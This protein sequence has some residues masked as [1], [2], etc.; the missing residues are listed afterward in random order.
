MRSIRP[1][2]L[3]SAVLQT[4][5]HVPHNELQM[6]KTNPGPLGV[7]APIWGVGFVSDRSSKSYIKDAHI[8]SLISSSVDLL[9]HRDHYFK[10]VTPNGPERKVKTKLGASLKWGSFQNGGAMTKQNYQPDE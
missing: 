3:P 6:H 8:Y 1:C 9:S 4:L 2:A 10:P 5:K 7:Q